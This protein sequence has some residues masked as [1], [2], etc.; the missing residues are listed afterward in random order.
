MNVTART[1]SLAICLLLP[2]STAA[3]GHHSGADGEPIHIEGVV[4]AVRMINPHAQ[5]L[6]EVADDAGVSATWRITA[7]PPAKLSYL[8]WTADTVPLGARVKVTGRPAGLGDRV[9]DLDLIE[10]EDGR[11]LVATLPTSLQ[12]GF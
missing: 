6:V 3:R 10:F 4:A 5:I 7:A 9:V 11:V 2:F 12:P 1:A 8:G